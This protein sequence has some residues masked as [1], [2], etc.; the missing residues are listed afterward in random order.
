M[1]VTQTLQYI[2]DL[3]ATIKHMHGALKPCGILLVTV[4]GISQ[5]YRGEW[6]KSWYWG[7]SVASVQ[8]LFGDEFGEECIEVKSYGNVFA[9]TIF[10]QGL[11]LE[12]VDAVDLEIPDAAYPMVVTVR[13]QKRTGE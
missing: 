7:F 8:R 13:A 4:P 12:E 5:I 1:I 3:R 9:A 2:Y 6:G 11:A 10:L